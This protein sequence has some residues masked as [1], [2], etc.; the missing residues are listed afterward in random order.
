MDLVNLHHTHSSSQ[1]VVYN[2]LPVT[3]VSPDNYYVIRVNKT[4]R[5]ESGDLEMVGSVWRHYHP[6]YHCKS[7]QSGAGQ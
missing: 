2:S 3:Y 5:F 6:Q 1:S 7:S 4:N